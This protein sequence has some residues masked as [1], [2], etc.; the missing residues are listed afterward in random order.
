MLDNSGGGVNE[1]GFGTTMFHVKHFCV[2]PGR[3]P[4]IM[5]FCKTTLWIKKSGLFFKEMTLTSFGP[6]ESDGDRIPCVWG[7]GD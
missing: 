1:A 6:F 7:D 2:N 3:R 4:G 5:R